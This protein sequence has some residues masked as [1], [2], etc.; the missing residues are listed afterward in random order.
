V[1]DGSTA[2]DRNTDARAVGFS[3]AV[4][5]TINNPPALWA[6]SDVTEQSAEIFDPN[7]GLA[8]RNL[9]EVSV[10]RWKD[11]TGADWIGGL[12]K[13]PDY[14]SV[15]RYPLVIQTYLF[16]AN[17]FMVSGTSTTAFAGR[18]LANAGIMVLQLSQHFDHQ[19][20]AQEAEEETLFCS[21]LAL[22]SCHLNLGSA[23]SSLP[24]RRLRTPEGLHGQAA[25]ALP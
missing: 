9:G 17:E 5:Q 3:V 21:A 6:T 8:D 23:A 18:P 2:A 20:T 25:A 11:K 10:V 14:V 4:K 12:I 7:P 15:R 19:V 16:N 24:T 1:G 13:P 22:R